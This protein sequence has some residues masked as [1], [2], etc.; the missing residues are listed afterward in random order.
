ME[1]VR[2]KVTGIHRDT[3]LPSSPSDSR[4]PSA[5]N[6]SSTSGTKDLSMPGSRKLAN[7][8][9]P[10][11]YQAHSSSEPTIRPH[12]R[13]AQYCIDDR[14][15]AQVDTYTKYTIS[16]INSNYKLLK[17]LTYNCRILFYYIFVRGRGGLAL[18]THKI[19]LVT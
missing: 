19:Y 3:E 4:R 8:H 17:I 10:T 9:P 13:G 11:T 7:A 12:P 6:P 14:S 18:G 5:T 2:S 1:N 16:T 15:A